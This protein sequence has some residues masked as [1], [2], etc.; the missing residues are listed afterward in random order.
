MTFFAAM[1]VLFFIAGVLL[2]ASSERH[3]HWAV[4]AGRARR[5]LL[6]VW[7]YGTVVLVGGLTQT[8]LRRDFSA[9]VAV[10]LADAATWLIPLV[11]PRSSAAPHGW[12]TTH[13]WYIRAYLW[14]LVLTPLL[15]RLARHLRVAFPLLCAAVVAVL[16]A[17]RLG[18]PALGSGPAHFVIGDVAVYGTFVVLGMAYHLGRLR[19][20]SAGQALPALLL[21]VLGIGM[22]VARAGVPPGGVNGSYPLT[23]LTGLAWLLLAAAFEHPIRTLAGADPIRRVACAI[24]RRAMT[25]YLWHP[26]AI[27]IGYWLVARVGIS[28]RTAPLGAAMVVAVT[29]A[30]TAFAAHAAGGAEDLAA[31]RRRNTC[32]RPNEAWRSLATRAVTGLV[33]TVIVLALPLTPEPTALA[34]RVGGSSRPVLPPPSYRPAPAEANFAAKAFKSRSGELRLEE[35]LSDRL[36]QATLDRWM[37]EQPDVGSVAVAVV[38]GKDTWAG[39]AHRLGA[40]S[41]TRAQDSYGIASATKTFTLGLALRAVDQGRIKLDTPVPSLPEVGR[42]PDGT[43]I[44][45]RHLL[46]HTSG[47]VDYPAARGYD[48]SLPLTPREAVRLSLDTPLQSPP[49]EQVIYANSN[50][51]Y[52]GLILEHVYRR[53]Y[54]KLVADLARTVGLPST[55]VDSEDRPGWTGFASGGVHSTVADLARW[56]AALFTPGRVLSPALS[57]QLRTLGPYNTALGTWPLCP[58]SSD[59][60]GQKH[61]T[62]IGQYTGHGGLYHTPQGVTVAVHI[63]PPVD[64]AD[65]KTS[66]L[67]ETLLRALGERS[68]PVRFAGN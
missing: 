60:G 2:A 50:Y 67:I 16:M 52:L 65:V 44:T 45:P 51:H 33:V 24:N 41:P 43:I 15:L 55:R 25:I 48:D 23:L 4:L 61:Y 13:L 6:P 8:D 27:V 56:G 29:V 31:N 36:L 30:V 10:T 59:E 37:E 47:L 17:G 64:S 68:D 18:I 28:G 34:S 3:S 66:S 40:H 12:L 5:L 62:A 9:G 38:A 46:Q 32:R 42:P 11:D 54:A 19:P 7:L 49:G 1:P 35:G 63:E 39:D 21:L 20:L 53:P 26:A 22:Y 14:I 58:C 57:S